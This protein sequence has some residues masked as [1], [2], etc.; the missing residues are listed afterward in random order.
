MPETNIYQPPEKSMFIDLLDT[1]AFLEKYEHSLRG[2]VL[3]TVHTKDDKG[4]DLVKQEW[5]QR[6]PAKMTDEG[7]SS[8]LG[9]L[10]TV[11]DKSMSLTD[12]SEEMI[13]TLIRQNSDAWLD[14]LCV[15][16][17]EFGLNNPSKIREVYYP[18]RNLI[19]AKFRSAIDGMTVNAISTTTNVQEVKNIAP[20][21]REEEQVGRPGFLS[22]LGIKV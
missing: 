20:A 10:R 13:D 8:T 21:P 7:V 4:R 6:Y 22:K 11:C 1:E 14:F 15:N 3:T 9:F 2:E 12:L 16:S 17:T 5:K 18:A 19:I